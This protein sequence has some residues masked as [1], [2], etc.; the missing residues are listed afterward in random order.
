MK[1]GLLKF[2]VAGVFFVLLRT[3]ANA[4]TATMRPDVHRPPA[5]SPAYVLLD[6]LLHLPSL[7]SVHQVSSRNKEGVN[8]D[9]NNWLYTDANRDRVIFDEAGP[10]CIRN[11]WGTNMG[12]GVIYSFYFDGE[13]EPRYRESIVNLYKGNHPDF[14]EPLVSYEKRGYFGKRPYAGNCFVPIPFAKSLKI[15]TKPAPQF[16]HILYERY[17]YG[18]PVQT[19][20]GQE[21]R[22]ALLDAFEKLGEDPV[23]DVGL[24]TTC[25]EKERLKPGERVTLLDLK[26]TAGIIRKIVIEADGSEISMQQ[27]EIWM[28]WDAHPR[29][30]VRAPIGIF[31]GSAVRASPM[32]SLPL[33][34]ER[35]E[36]GRVRLSC[37][38]PMPFWQQAEITL[39]NR[40]T[41]ELGPLKA[42]VA[43]ASNDLKPDRSGYFTTVYR[44]GKTTYGQDWRLFESPGTGWFVGAVQ[45]MHNEHYCEGDE[46]FYM[47]DAISPQ[48]NGTGT[49]DYYL[50]C[51][52]PNRKYDSPFACSVEN[53]YQQGGG[54]NRGAHRIPCSYA[55]FHLEMPIPFYRSM[56]A[57][58]QHGGASDIRSDYRSLAFCYLRKHTALHQTDYIDVGNETNEAVHN[59]HATAATLTGRVQASPEGNDFETSSSDVGRQHT[60]GEITFTVAIDPNNQGVRL[61]R[62]LDQGSLRQAAHVYVD[63]QYAGHWYHANHNE[64]LRW[65]DSDFDLHPQYTQGKKSLDINLK[66]E[67]EGQRGPFTDFEYKIYCLEQ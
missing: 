34:V 15:V 5:S 29:M 2:C 60:G 28:T 13:K 10:G 14:P 51:F 46:H 18:T 50:G 39:V 54:N 44:E 16:Y 27:N 32:Q 47:D 22:I 17:P 38:F 24:E 55:R 62:R 37:Y 52:W 40:S 25:T 26:Q 66:I 9:A 11:I 49:E 58:I 57:R 61:R 36:T 48:I 1:K 21:D 20:T 63:G 64:H 7:Y 31:F 59:Y 8:G 43:V 30:D 4:E 45:S 65:Y 12:D 6:R 67:T 3:P 23:G 19:F 53:I 35:T 33:K 56:D 42:E 41:Y